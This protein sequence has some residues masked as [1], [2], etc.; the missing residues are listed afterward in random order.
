MPTFSVVV[1]AYNVAE[2]LPAC[3]D[4]L[5]AQSF[6][7]WESIVVVDA[8][9]DNC[10]EIA[11]R[12]EQ[13]DCRF[14]VIAK[15]ENEGTHLARRSGTL[16]ATGE[17]ITYLD[18]DDELAPNALQEVHDALNGA[19]CDLL[20]F[21]VVVKEAGATKEACEACEE[22]A[23]RQFPPC[24]G[25]QSLF[26]TFDER[27]GYEQGWRMW[28]N[29]VRAHAAQQ[30]FSAMTCDRL[31]RSQ[32]SYEFFVLMSF[33]DSFVTR[34]DIRGYV[35][36]YGRGVSGFQRLSVERFVSCAMQFESV[37]GAM[38]AYAASFE[39][40]DMTEAAAGARLKLTEEVFNE[41]HNRVADEDKI[42]AAENVV[43]LLGADA[44]AAE[45][46][47]WVRDDAYAYWAQGKD[48]PDDAPLHA[49][50][51][52]AREL[53]A[54]CSPSE[55]Y[56]AFEKA[57]EGHLHDLENRRKANSGVKGF[58]RGVVRSLRK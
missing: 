18:G 39:K 26:I 46:E 6:S 49:W 55:R 9:P 14:K 13:K 33:V 34:T 5:L 4:S 3:L 48:L 47:R 25:E 7:D 36:Q 2:Y 21:G 38:A 10:A 20:R 56:T 51:A 28:S 37:F 41:W 27:G 50:H 31:G 1:L 17:W 16:A 30:A 12:F 42:V 53:A 54:S 22:S 44:V 35:Y 15:T 43:D 8:S 19:D 23:N 11:K 58:L 24:T 29:V 52:L 32:D 40:Y 45:L 57:A